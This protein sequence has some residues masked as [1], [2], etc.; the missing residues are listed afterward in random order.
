MSVE[1]LSERVLIPTQPFDSNDVPQFSELV[2]TAKD[3]FLSELNQYF[4]YRTSDATQK[5]SE[6]PNIQ[7]FALG[8][9]TGERSLQTVVNTIVSYGDTPDKFPMISITS[10]R[11]KEKKLGIGSNFVAS[12]QYPPSVV[13]TEAGPFNIDHGSSDPW[14]LT[15]ETCP[16]G[17]LD[18]KVTSSVTFPSSYFADP[19]AVTASEIC[20]FVNQSQALYYRFS[21]TGDGCLRLEAGGSGSSRGLSRYIGVVSATGNLLT[22]FGLTE[23]DSDNHLNSDNPPAN[24][25][26]V[27]ADMTINIDVVTDS[28]VTRTELQ[29]LVS[30]FFTFYLEKR[31]FQ[32]LGRSYFDRDLD[33]E[34]WFHILLNNKFSWSTEITK[35]RQGGEQYDKIYAV[36]GSVPIFIEDFVNRYL[37]NESYSFYEQ[38]TR[39][40]SGAASDT[41]D[42]R[43]YSYDIPSG[44]YETGINYSKK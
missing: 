32:L 7:K 35:D 34:E 43:A 11:F 14:I 8:A 28:L 31:R 5:I 26:V 40:V 18:E 24:R 19:T 39:S 4:N 38:N 13:G 1:N 17:D 16:S 42:E 41:E 27:A 2:E 6:T 44:D 12:V 33:P 15:I 23:G 3:V 37:T 29:D 25:Y 9:G 30:T 21:L 22:Q 20:R 10:A 36:R